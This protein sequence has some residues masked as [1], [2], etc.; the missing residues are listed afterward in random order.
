MKKVQFSLTTGGADL[1]RKVK[2]IDK[3][4]SAGEEVLVSV[5]VKRG[6]GRIFDSCQAKL[7]SI[8]QMLTNAQKVAPM[9]KKNNGWQTLVR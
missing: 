3:F 5:Q 9:S 6:Q 8:T 7:L 1:E 4:L 2:Q